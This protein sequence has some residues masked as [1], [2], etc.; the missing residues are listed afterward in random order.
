MAVITRSF[1]M[2]AYG[3]HHRDVPT[4]TPPLILVVYARGHAGLRDLR[5]SRGRYGMSEL[6][7]SDC[8]WQSMALRFSRHRGHRIVERRDLVHRASA[9]ASS[10]PS[11]VRIRR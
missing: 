2:A 7:L 5:F 3:E 11:R 4:L 6:C 8:L 1:N 9:T 10:T